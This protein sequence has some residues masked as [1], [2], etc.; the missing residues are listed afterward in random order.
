MNGEQV[1]FDEGD[2]APFLALKDGSCEL[3]LI[4][5]AD[6]YPDEAEVVAGGYDAQPLSARGRRQAHALAERLQGTELTAIYSSPIRRA[7]QTALCLGEALGLPVQER[8]TL[9][10]V[11]LLPGPSYAGTGDALACIRAM[12]AHN[13]SAEAAVMR[14]GNWSLVPGCEPSEHLRSR[15]TQTICDIAE[16]HASQ[17]VALVTHSGSINAF[18]AATLG[19]ACDFFCPFENTSLSVLRVNGSRCVLLQLNDTAHLYQQDTHERKQRNNAYAEE[20]V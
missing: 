17:R 11:G 12:R 6:A 8:E 7:W 2:R 9:R 13:R 14:A 3:V 18:L 5:H 15:M 10:D 19:L 1:L 16:H 4:R 20:R